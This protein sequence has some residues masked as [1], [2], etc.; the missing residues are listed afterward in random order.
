MLNHQVRHGW[1]RLEK[2]RTLEPSA[3][4]AFTLCTSCWLLSVRRR[5]RRSTDLVDVSFIAGDFYSILTCFD[6]DV[7]QPIE[8][9]AS[10]FFQSLRM[11]VHVFFFFVCVSW[12]QDFLLRLHKRLLDELPSLWLQKDAL[13]RRLRSLHSATRCRQLQQAGLEWMDR[14]TIEKTLVLVLCCQLIPALQQT[15]SASTLS[16]DGWKWQMMNVAKSCWG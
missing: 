7:F 13:L 14:D 15:P 11:C 6:S 10:L 3:Q 8:A 16:T 12:M 5:G 1:K 4:P 9:G 2:H